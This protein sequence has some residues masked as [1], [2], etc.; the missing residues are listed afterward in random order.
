MKIE[1]HHKCSDFNSYRASRCKS[2]FN[3]E[4]GCNFDLEV[5]L[6]IDDN[7]WK[8]GL[9][10]GPSGS[11]KTS[12]GKKVFGEE[13]F[14][15]PE[16]WASDKPIIDDIGYEKGFEDITRSLSGVGLGSVPTW[17]RPYCVLSNGEKFRANLA[18]IICDEPDKIVVDEFSSVVDR[19]VARIGAYAFAKNWRRIK[20]QAKCILLSCHYDVIDWLEPDWVFDIA[21][22]KYQGRGL[23][24]RPEIKLEIYATNWRFWPLF[25]PHHYLKV[26]RMP[27]SVV[28]IGVINGTLVAHG[29]MAPKPK[30]K[31]VE[32]RG[33]RLVIM[34]EWQGLGIGHRFASYIHQLQLEGRGVLKGRHITSLSITSHPALIKLRKKD[35]RY[36]FVKARLYGQ[37][38]KTAM[39]SIKRSGDIKSLGFAK[40]GGHFR[41]TVT[42]RYV[43]NGEI[44]YEK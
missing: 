44:K 21:T 16:S 20:K 37:K 31:S 32:A 24:R 6:P 4:S 36:K 10:V 25:R 26:G 13:Y 33:G 15:N 22:G 3:V 14:Y 1:I 28:Y 12:I 11:G 30:G 8:L 2:L 34:P 41:S 35:N 39:K 9:V 29:A 27:A 43:G 42:F 17:L 23:W 5:D 7:E 18:K 38:P 40:F 19:Q